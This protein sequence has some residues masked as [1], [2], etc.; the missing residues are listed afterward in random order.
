M[1]AQSDQQFMYS[2]FV[3]ARRFSDFR[4]RHIATLGSQKHQYASR[5]VNRWHNI[6]IAVS[7]IKDAFRALIH[8][9]AYGS[10]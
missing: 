9:I 1:M 6:F 5:S 8:E 7:H 3:P 4:N 2:A 10:A